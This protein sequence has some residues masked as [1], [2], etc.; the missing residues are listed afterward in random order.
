MQKDHVLKGCFLREKLV[1]SSG[2]S[3]WKLFCSKITIVRFL[4]ISVVLYYKLYCV[5]NYVI[6]WLLPT[7]P[8]GI[9]DIIWLLESSYF[10]S[11]WLIIKIV[12]WKDSHTKRIILVVINKTLELLLPT[13]NYIFFIEYSIKVLSRMHFV[14]CY[15]YSLCFSYLNVV[16]LNIVPFFRDAI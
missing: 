14:I 10:E 6:D 15:Y 16:L 12:L 7:L 2:R 9:W 11:N 13:T 4:W 1:F 8:T 5:L 3:V